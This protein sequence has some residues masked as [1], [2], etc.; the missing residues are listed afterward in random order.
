MKVYLLLLDHSVMK[1]FRRL[2]QRFSHEIL[3]MT[4]EQ[5]LRFGLDKD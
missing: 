2:M 5:L 4:R 3:T 1:L